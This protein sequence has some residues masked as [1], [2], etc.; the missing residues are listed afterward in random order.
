MRT[1][2]IHIILIFLSVAT[3]HAQSQKS[4]SLFSLGV[5]LYN[6]QQYEKAIISFEACDSLDKV[7]VSSDTIKSVINLIQRQSYMADC[8]HRLGRYYDAIKIEK[9][10]VKIIGLLIGTEHLLYK[11]SL[12]NLALYNYEVGNYEEAVHLSKQALEIHRK[13]IGTANNE[14]AILLGNIALYQH[15][16]GNNIEAV[17]FGKQAQD[18]HRKVLDTENPTYARLL[19]NLALYQHEL[20]NYSE[21]V[22]LAENA[23][24]IYEK[25]GGQK[26]SDYTILLLGLSRYQYELGNYLEAVRLA[27]KALKICKKVLGIEHPDYA[28]SLSYLAQYKCALSNYFEAKCLVEE[29]LRIQKKFGLQNLSY[30]VSLSIFASCQY[31]LSNYSDAVRLGEQ[32]LE[33][34]RNILGTETSDYAILLN[35]LS[36]YKNKIGNYFEAECLIKQALEIDRKVLGTEHPKYAT[37]LNNLALYQSNLGNYAEAVHLAEQALEVYSKVLGTEHPGYATLLNNLAKYHYQN[38]NFNK[39]TYYA[40]SCTIL[41]TSIVANTFSVLTSNERATFWNKYSNWFTKDLPKYTYT[42]PTDTLC[43]TAYNGALLSKGLILNSEIEMRKLLHESGDAE[44][45]SLYDEMH[46]NK[47]QLQ[48]LYEKPIAER[49]ISTDSLESV[50]NKQEQQLMQ[51]SKVYGDY[52]KNLRINWKDVQGKLTDKDVAIEFVSFPLNNDSMMYM[53]LV[54]KKGMEYPKMVRLFEEKQLKEIRK[55]YDGR[56]TASLVW[57][58]LAMYINNMKNIYFGASG[59]L[60]NVAIEQVPHWGEDC[61]MSDKWNIYRLSSTRELALIKDRNAVKQA[62][63]YGGIRY[64]AGT[65][66]LANDSRRFGGKRDMSMELFDIAD[67]LN[68]RSGVNYLPGTKTEAENIYKTLKQK[69]ITAT[70]KMDTLATEGAFKDLSGRKNNLLHITTHGF[71]W[72]EREVSMMRDL[73]F[74]MFGDVR[75]RYVEDKALTRSGLLMAGANNALMGKKLPEGVNDGILTAKEI[76]QLDLRGLDLVVMAAC[77]TGLGEITGDGV[78]GLQRGFK[79]AGANTLMMSLWKV[80]DDATQMLMTQFYKNL[81]AGKSKYESL[82]LAQKYVREYEKEVE[83]RSDERPKWS[84]NAKEQA[85]KEAQKENRKI[86]PF[87]APEYWAAFILMDAVD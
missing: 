46:L 18:I 35:Q 39:N 57:K 25:T 87:Q 86:R 78:F 23:L 30:V 5:E 24:E 1:K 21:A 8:Y 27:E 85:R 76:A 63:V 34:Y 66:L 67:S 20:G 9:P 47:L 32:A 26:Y 4:D 2:L 75:P 12:S 6:N 69:H 17:H 58:P 54:L 3:S 22:R 77:Q 60:Y 61:L 51:K 59:E 65:E 7:E 68:I 36:G 79:K 33:I 56:E 71:Y 84:A 62:A 29:S 72:T 42:Y 15:C 10:I 43:F 83:V 45:D 40:S 80:D 28:R 52:T 41:N 44:I 82:R 13:V 11:T 81:T 73:D 74:L 49:Y 14:Y 37:S 19:G 53:A 16:L 64:D 50:V 70:L 38:G 31:G 55:K 48:R